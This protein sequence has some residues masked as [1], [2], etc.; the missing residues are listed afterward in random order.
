MPG[1]WML[2]S[3]VAICAALEPF[4]ILSTLTRLLADQ[5]I[6]ETDRSQRRKDKFD[7]RVRTKGYELLRASLRELFYEQTSKEQETT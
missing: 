6:D 7:R 4:S 1:E 2:Y 3:P 5:M